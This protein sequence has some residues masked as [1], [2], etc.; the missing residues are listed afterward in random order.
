MPYEY[1]AMAFLHRY[2]TLL[3]TDDTNRCR[4]FTGACQG[5]TLQDRAVYV[6]SNSRQIQVEQFQF[7][8]CQTLYALPVAR[9]C[10]VLPSLPAS[11]LLDHFKVGEGGCKAKQ[12]LGKGAGKVC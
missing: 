5:W 11:A 2:G 8:R 7:Q 6:R 12:I 1:V 3:Y 9:V 10:V 4:M